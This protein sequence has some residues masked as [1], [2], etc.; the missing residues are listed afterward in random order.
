M[1]AMR[2]PSLVSSVNATTAVEFALVLPAFLMLLLGIMYGS[3]AIYTAASMHFAVEGAARFYSVSS[4]ISGQ[5]GSAATTQSNAKTLYHG[6]GSPTFTASNPAC[7]C[8][9]NGTLNVVF[10]AGMAQWTIPLSATACFP[11]NIWSS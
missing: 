1:T 10:N 11:A 7:G 5:C 2:R 9:V 3:L 8:Q 6:T 4:V